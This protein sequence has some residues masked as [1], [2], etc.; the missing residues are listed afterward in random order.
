[1]QLVY[2]LLLI[3]ALIVVLYLFRRA[4]HRRHLLERSII[5]RHPLVSKE[6]KMSGSARSEMRSTSHA[7]TVMDTMAR[8]NP[9]TEPPASRS[10]TEPPTPPKDGSKPS[11]RARRQR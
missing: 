11:G 9:G 8:S 5:R 6:R 7:T 4:Q 2:A 10:R 3:G 1:M